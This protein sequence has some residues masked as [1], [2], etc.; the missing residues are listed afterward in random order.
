MACAE[1][2]TNG[3]IVIIDSIEN[4]STMTMLTSQLDACVL[5]GF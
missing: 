3:V 5:L 4:Q 1:V 2:E